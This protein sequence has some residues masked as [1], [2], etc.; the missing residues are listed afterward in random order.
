M[1][2]KQVCIALVGAGYAAFLHGNGY[3]KGCGV[4]VRLKTIVDIDISKAE[5]N[6]YPCGFEQARAEFHAIL[7]D[8]EID[9][10]DLVTPP[11]LLAD[12]VEKA[13]RAGKH[14]ICEKR[15]V[16]YNG[17]PGDEKPIGLKVPKPVM[18]KEVM[19]DL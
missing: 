3:K 7:A 1:D 6:C 5:A 17:R 16:G 13:C 9:V 19:V 4:P 2:T 12:M 8:P 14:V 11:F 10:V 18:F 15:P